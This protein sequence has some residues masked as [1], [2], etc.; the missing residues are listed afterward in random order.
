MN[1]LVS[2]IEDLKSS[3]VQ[4]KVDERIEEFKRIGCKGNERWFSELSFCV[5]TANSS[6]RLAIDIQEELG[7]EGFIELSPSDLQ[8]RL[9]DLGHRF[10]RTRAEY[11][12]KNREFS[13]S[14]KDVIDSFSDSR[15]ARDWLAEDVMGIGYKEGSH[16]LRNVGYDNVMIVDRHILRILCDE[17]V[18]KEEPNTLT[19][20]RYLNI[21]EEVEDL[22]DKTNLSL[23]E[24]DLYLWYLETGKILK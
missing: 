22:A 4:R 19:E 5:L 1:S 2:R 10:Y 9:E 16:F 13:D 7:A 18:I 17:C 11:I 23:G 21:E 8:D 15:E 24:I 3:E 14:I 12:V 20:K 6:A